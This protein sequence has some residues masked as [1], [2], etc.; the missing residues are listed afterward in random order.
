[1]ERFE[2]GDPVCARARLFEGPP[3][4]ADVH[5]VSGGRAADHDA[6]ADEIVHL[7]DR[8]RDHVDLRV[9]AAHAFE[10]AAL[11]MGVRDFAADR[12]FFR[13]HEHIKRADFGAGRCFVEGEDPVII[14]GDFKFRRDFLLKAV[15]KT[16]LEI[17]EV[18]H[19]ASVFTAASGGK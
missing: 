8:L 5:A 16:P 7:A 18:H 15:Q 11:G 2:K 12:D 17:A 3:A 9:R 19:A 13:L 14:A 6:V 10:I 4:G 1:M